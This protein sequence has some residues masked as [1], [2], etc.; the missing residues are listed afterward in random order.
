MKPLTARG[1]RAMLTRSGVD[2]SQLEIGD[3][4]RVWTDLQ[5]GRSSTSVII[6]GPRD[7]RW[8]AWCVLSGRP[9][10]GCAP[11]PEYDMWSRR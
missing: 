6:R 9:G 2:A 10:L 1:V 11:Y 5:T 8:A 7:A 3:D 4:S